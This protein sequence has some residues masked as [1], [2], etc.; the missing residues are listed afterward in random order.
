[1]R[2]GLSTAV[3]CAF[4]WTLALEAAEQEVPTQGLAPTNL[5][6][7]DGHWTAND[8]PP[9]VE[10]FQVHVVAIGDTLWAIAERYMDDPFLW[11]QLWEA[12]RHIVNPHW[13]YP[14]DQVLIRPLTQITDAV[15]P[16]PP[17]Q[18]PPEPE[19]TGPRRVQLPNL[20][21]SREDGVLPP[22]RFVFQAEERPEVPEVKASDLYCSGFVTTQNLSGSPEVMAMFSDG[23]RILSTEGHYVYVRQGAADGLRP[24]DLMTVI[25]PTRNVNSTRD[26]VGRLGRHYLELGHLRAVTV[27]AEFSLARVINSCDSIEVGDQVVDFEAID[28]PEL[29][30]NRPFSSQLPRTGNITGAIAVSR[31]AL[32][33]SKSPT[34]GGTGKTA[35]SRSSHLRELTGGVTS[36]GQIVYVDLGAGDGIEAGNIFLIYR[37]LD[38][39]NRLFDIDGEARRLLADER[40]VIGELV[41]LKVEERAAT[42]LIT[43][44]S[45]GV[46][47]GDLVE[48]R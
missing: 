7:R 13:I 37:P 15:P 30:R 36:E 44:S 3:F 24:G 20:L 6:Q 16:P 43:F 19:P 27:Q 11:P 46:V 48:L 18:I 26:N 5:Q 17:P 28:F 39:S 8:V 14:E 31:D 25:R 41:V 47:P 33:N 2:K 32:S 1:M 22:D 4:F 40:I 10:D 38:F 12:N 45:T 29:P 35:G 9:D 42:A 21:L 23:E 34:M